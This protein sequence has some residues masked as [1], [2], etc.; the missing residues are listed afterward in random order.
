ME[1]ARPKVFTPEAISVS[2]GNLANDEVTSIACSREE[3]MEGF[4]A[5]LGETLRDEARMRRLWYDL[6]ATRASS[7]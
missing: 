3:L 6:R 1:L 2:R 4:L 7:A 5:K